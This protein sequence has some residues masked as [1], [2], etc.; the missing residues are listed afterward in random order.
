MSFLLQ[1]PYFAMV[2]DPRRPGKFRKV[3]KQIPAYIPEHD[4]DVLA[5]VRKSAYR[6]DMCL[7]NFM[8]IRFGK[9][10]NTL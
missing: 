10:S 3:K 7:F 2:E 8:G 4:A 1:D 5:E 9:F 6:L